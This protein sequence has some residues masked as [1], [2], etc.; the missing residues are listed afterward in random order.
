[1]SNLPNSGRPARRG[2]VWRILGRTAVVVAAL[3]LV[4]SGTVYGVSSHMLSSTHTVPEHPLVVRTDSATI[5][6]G[7]H[8]A[9]IRGCVDCHAP[10][11]GGAMVID[12]PA[13]G[14]IG[15]ANLTAGRDGG[16][17]TDRDWERAVRHGVR[18][19]GRP[20][21]VMPSEEF[22]G[23]SDDDLGAIAAYV[24]SL[25]PVRRAKLPVELGPVLRA[26]ATAGQVKVGAD[27]IDHQRTHPVSVVA[28][29]T[30]TYGKY[31]AQGCTGC[32]GTGF[33]G[34][35]IPGAPPDWKPAANITPS[36]IGRYSHDDFAR[37]LRTGKRPDGSAVDTL[38]PWR[39]T[40]SM[41][42]TEIA[43]LYAF[44]KTVPA[45]EYGQ[46]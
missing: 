18:R 20:Y 22:T 26:L 24:R 11:F 13:I 7:Q 45:R 16:P 39:L 42:D 3:V 23:M 17:L 34:G 38:M 41:T 37:I 14:R 5:A 1:M 44:L 33:S 21:L 6:R 28:E 2:R 40:K 29:P 19:D 4:A 30:A 8:L 46:R 32:H 25:P 9:T 27:I 35:K 31:L 10:D 15:G 43:A 36:G 12:E